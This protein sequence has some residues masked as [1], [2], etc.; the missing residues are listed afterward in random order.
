MGDGEYAGL[1]RAAAAATTA[2]WAV[3]ALGYPP[4]PPSPPIPIPNS[5]VDL[6]AT[7]PG[8]HSMVS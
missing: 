5:I 8:V 7:A 1:V 4:P 3:L 6:S 2:A